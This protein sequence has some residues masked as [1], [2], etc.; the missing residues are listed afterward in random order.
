MT[1]KNIAQDLVHLSANKPVTL[2]LTMQHVTGSSNILEILNKFGH[3]S[4]H[5]SVPE[6]DT[7]LATKQLETGSIIQ[8]SFQEEYLCTVVWDDND[9]SE[10]T[11]TGVCILIILMIC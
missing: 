11:V 6:Q 10:E 1:T 8:R 5:S 3:A 9:F 2:G 7:A 4:C